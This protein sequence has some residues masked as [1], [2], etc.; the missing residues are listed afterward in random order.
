VPPPLINNSESEHNGRVQIYPRTGLISWTSIKPV[1]GHN[2]AAPDDPLRYEPTT[3]PGVR[4]PSVFLEDGSAVYDRLGPWFTLLAVGVGPSEALVAAAG[5][6]GV[7]LALLAT[8]DPVARAVYG[9]GLLLVRPDHHIAWR[10]SALEDARGADAVI[11]R[12][13]GW[14]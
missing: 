10:G 5:R 12:A 14:E 2:A 11:G 1:A 9:R 6:R 13:L 4:L 7:P 8:D 3:I